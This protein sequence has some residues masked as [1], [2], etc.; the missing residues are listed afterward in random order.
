MLGQTET[1]QQLSCVNGDILCNPRNW[2]A[3]SSPSTELPSVLVPCHAQ[4]LEGVTVLS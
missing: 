2:C 4:Q 3:L 1:T